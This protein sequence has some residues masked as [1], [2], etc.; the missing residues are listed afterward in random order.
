[1]LNL[2]VETNG[3]IHKSQGAIFFTDEDEGIVGF[4]DD[5][6]RNSVSLDLS[7][8]VSFRLESRSVE[9][10]CAGRGTVTFAEVLLV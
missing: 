3:E 10:L 6:S 8:E 1:M 2:T 9:V 7:G 4:V 5:T